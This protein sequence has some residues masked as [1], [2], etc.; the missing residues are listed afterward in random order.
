MDSLNTVNL[1]QTQMDIYM[2]SEQLTILMNGSAN[3][4]ALQFA[5]A[6]NHVVTRT[7]VDIYALSGNNAA[8]NFIKFFAGAQAIEANKTTVKRIAIRCTSCGASFEGIEGSPSK[9]PCCGSFY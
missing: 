1:M 2:R 4:A 3:S 8:K 5:N 7:D 6:L 9:C